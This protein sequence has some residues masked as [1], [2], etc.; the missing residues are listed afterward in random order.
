MGIRISSILKEKTGG[1]CLVNH[2]VPTNK[3][4]IVIF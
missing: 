1:G 4:N 2:Y 3:Y